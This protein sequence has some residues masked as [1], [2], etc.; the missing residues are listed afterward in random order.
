MF[1]RSLN[2]TQLNTDSAHKSEV[3]F[4]LTKLHNFNLKFKIFLLI[5][6]WVR[7]KVQLQSKSNSDI[8]HANSNYANRIKSKP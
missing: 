2:L 1:E 3:S 4:R 8:T 6:V 5:P 7:V